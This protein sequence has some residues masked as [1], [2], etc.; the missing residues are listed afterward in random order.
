[1]GKTTLGGLLALGYQVAVS[2]K[3]ESTIIDTG[4]VSISIETID[5]VNKS[6]VQV[7]GTDRKVQI[8][9]GNRNWY[10]VCPARIRSARD[11]CNLSIPCLYGKELLR[12]ILGLKQVVAAEAAALGLDGPWITKSYMEMVLET[13]GI[14]C[15]I[16]FLS[17]LF[18]F[19]CKWNNFYVIWIPY[20]WFHW[21]HDSTFESW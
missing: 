17:S 8:L 3:R 21:G 4:K 15:A 2:Y 16:T 20:G 12:L 10:Y 7:K 5:D 19:K 18:R 14:S 13:K 11:F 6:F 9:L 1:M